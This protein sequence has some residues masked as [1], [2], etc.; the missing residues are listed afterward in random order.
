MPDTDTATSWPITWAI[1]IVNASHWVGLTLPGIIELPGSLDGM[2]YS[3]IPL[4][5]PE[6]NMRMSLP[7]FISDTAIVFKAPWDST[8]AS[9]AD[10]ASNLLGADR[11]GKPV[12]SAILAATFSAYPV[13]VLSPVPTAVPP[14]ANS[15]KCSRLD[16]MVLMP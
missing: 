8:T 9:W 2:M 5:G 6:A 3:P 11:N 14:R 12:S 16:S 10:R 13:G 7:I 1:A 4:L 15:D